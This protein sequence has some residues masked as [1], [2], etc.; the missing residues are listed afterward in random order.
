MRILILG[1]TGRAR[2]LADTL[3]RMGALVTTSL[4]GRTG[5]HRAVAGDVRVGGFGGVEGLAAWLRA[6]R[7]DVVVDATHAFAAQMSAN[8]VAACAG[9]GVPLARY[10]PPSWRDAEGSEAWTWVPDHASAASAAAETDG[11]VLLTVGRQP[12]PAYG[13]LAGHEVLARMVDAPEAPPPSGWTYLR[14]RGPFEPAA[15]RELLVGPPRISCLVSKDSGGARLDAKLVAAGE[16]GV[17]VVMVSRP[18]LPAADAS[19]AD[20]RG[21]LDWISGHRAP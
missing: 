18:A 10:E 9:T 21:V 5:E 7:P 19:L 17:G 3:T 16:L 15:E 20:E 6:E 14:R 8:A 13:A 12:L 2:R 4:A 1:G 11:A